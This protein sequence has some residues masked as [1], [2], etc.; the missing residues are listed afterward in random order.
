MCHCTVNN[1]DHLMSY[2]IVLYYAC[3][4]LPLLHQQSFNVK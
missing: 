2:D 1:E 3:M 4:Q